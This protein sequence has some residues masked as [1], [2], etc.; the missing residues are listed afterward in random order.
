[1]LH[2]QHRQLHVRRHAQLVED[3]VAVAVHGLRRKVQIRRDVVHALAVH[4]HERDLHLPSRQLVERRHALLVERLKRQ[5]LGDVRADEPLAG[6]GP[7]DRRGDFLRRAALGDET[8]SAGA[9][10]LRREGRVPSA[11]QHHHLGA[12]LGLQD[13]PRRFQS[14]HAGHRYLQ[15]GDMRVEPARQLH[16]LL[17]ALGL[18]HHVDGLDIAQQAD[19]AGAEQAVIVGD[20]CPYH[21]LGMIYPYCGGKIKRRLGGCK[22]AR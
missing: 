21:L 4:H 20:Y 3:A 11:R 14:T 15:R 17:P 22:T 7:L 13:A 8:A 12:G 5:A 1:M 2:R 6:V 16:G 18:A 19:H 9:Q 10:R